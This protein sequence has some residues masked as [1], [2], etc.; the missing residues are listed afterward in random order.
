M[1]KITSSGP[2]LLPK[3]KELV[4]LTRDI[5]F[6]GSTEAVDTKLDELIEAV[7]EITER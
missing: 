3:L 7:K 4:D 1:A 5:K 6:Q 2:N